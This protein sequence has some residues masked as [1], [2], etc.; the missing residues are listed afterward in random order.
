M[1]VDGITEI[2]PGSVGMLPGGL[3]RLI[4]PKPPSSNRYWR[5]YRNRVVKS[6]E[7]LSFIALVDTLARNLK[8]RPILTGDVAVDVCWYRGAKRGD[9]DNLAKCALDALKNGIVF[10]DDSQVA[11][12]SMHRR[13]G[14][15]PERVEVTVWR[16]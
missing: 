11:E 14:T 16:L 8:I 5:V 6:K 7:A 12:L 1:A 4:L 15:K 10:R 13:D 2:G 9:L 3:I